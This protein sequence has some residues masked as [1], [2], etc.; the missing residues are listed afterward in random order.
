MNHLCPLITHSSPSLVAVVPITVGA[1]VFDLYAPRRLASYGLTAVSVLLA[2]SLVVQAVWPLILD[3]IPALLAIPAAYLAALVARID[4]Q[5]LGLRA[6]RAHLARTESL[7]HHVVQN[8]FDAVLTI[9]EDGD[10]VDAR[11][12]KGLPMGLDQQAL[13][14]VRSWKFKP[15][16]IGG[17]PGRA[18]ITVSVAFR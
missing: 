2:A 17:I 13:E 12:L 18:T 3:V 9:D 6:Q 14:A 4:Q 8:S 11:V 1:L 7:M 5:T 15:A 16:V 10:V